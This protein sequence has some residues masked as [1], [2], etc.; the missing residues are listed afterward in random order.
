MG[1]KTAYIELNN[2]NQIGYLHNTF[3]Q[4]NFSYLGI[5]FFPCVTVTS[6]SE[7]LSLKFDYFVLDIGVVN[8]HTEKT[9]FSCDTRFLVC[10]LSKWKAHKT[11]AKLENLFQQNK[12]YRA[13]VTVL[14]NLAMKNYYFPAISHLSLCII[15][16]PFIPNP[17]HLKP[18]VFH[19]FHQFLERN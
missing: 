18:D 2:T 15:S 12:N 5:T 6:L 3:T 19:V 17:F 7:I 8:A 4:K 1:K 13:N 14:N 10:S 16:F 11:K 9:F